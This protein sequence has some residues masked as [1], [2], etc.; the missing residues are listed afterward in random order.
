MNGEHRIEGN[1][2]ACGV[3]G[4]MNRKSRCLRK[5]GDGKGERTAV[6]GLGGPIGDTVFEKLVLNS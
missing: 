1:V 2:A 6:A 5:P 4:C 3:V